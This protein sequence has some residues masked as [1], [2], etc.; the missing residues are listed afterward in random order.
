MPSLTYKE[1]ASLILSKNPNP[2]NKFTTFIETGTYMGD[3]IFSMNPYFNELHTI[4]LSERLYESAKEKAKTFLNNK[5]QFHHGDSSVVLPELLPK[6][7]SPTI[8]WLDGHFCHY[9]SAQGPK[10]CPLLEEISAIRDTLN[11]P[12]IIIIDDARL[13]D[14]VFGEDWT[15]INE[16]SILSILTS[17]PS[18][19]YHCHFYIPSHIHPKDRLVIFI[20]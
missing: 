6:I 17:H 12:A 3:T 13:F 20:R 8:F 11:H 5:I 7:N 14:K 15:G 16:K 4:E 9:D 10:D 18:Q 1:I 2:M 19:R